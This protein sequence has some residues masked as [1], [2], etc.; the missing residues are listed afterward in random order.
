MSEEQKKDTG[1][2]YVIKLQGHLDTNWSEWFY[3][4]TITHEPNGITT[5]CGLLPDQV[6]LHSIL[7]RI[8]DLNLKLINVQKVDDVNQDELDTQN[9][10]VE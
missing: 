10:T 9:D 2:I 1:D 6:V 3:G 8:R 7:E 4:L 5:L